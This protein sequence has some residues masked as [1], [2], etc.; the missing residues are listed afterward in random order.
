MTDVPRTPPLR[1]V[2]ADEPRPGASGAER[3][4]LAEELLDGLQG[5]LQRGLVPDDVGL[6][7]AL[8]PAWSERP[9]GPTLDRL[10]ASGRLRQVVV[11]SEAHLALPHG[12]SIPAGRSTTDQAFELEVATDL[13]AERAL[14]WRVACVVLGLAALALGR[15]LLLDALT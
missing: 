9:L 8:L 13:E 3:D 2:G 6:L 11:G 15:E 10:V 7:R 5:M 14:L 1:L 12:D 4:E